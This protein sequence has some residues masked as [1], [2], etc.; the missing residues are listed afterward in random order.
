MGCGNCPAGSHRCHIVHFSIGLEETDDRHLKLRTVH[1]YFHRGHINAGTGHVVCDFKRIDPGSQGQH[2]CG[3]WNHNRSS[4]AGTYRD[5]NHI[6]SERSFHGID[7]SGSGSNAAAVAICDTIPV[8]MVSYQQV[9]FKEYE[10]MINWCPWLL[11]FCA[12][13]MRNFIWEQ[14]ITFQKIP[15]R[16]KENE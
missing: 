5:H 6:F 13:H 7:G 1:C 14:R 8:R 10:W 15:D 11:K 16:E 4:T 9:P 12:K 2:C 3:F